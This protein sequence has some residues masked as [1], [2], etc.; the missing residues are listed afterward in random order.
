M[1]LDNA[2]AHGNTTNLPHLLHARIEFLRKR[3]N[4]TLHPMNLGL[5]ACLKKRH[6]KKVILR[7]L[8][9]IKSD[10]YENL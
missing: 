2:S 3:T 6:K 5:I 8:D 10:I 7:A 9:L 1:L 4:P